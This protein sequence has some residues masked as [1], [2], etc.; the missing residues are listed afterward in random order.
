MSQRNLLH[1]AIV[2]ERVKLVSKL[3]NNG[4]DVDAKDDNIYSPLH[5][6]VKTRNVEIIKLL[7]DAGADPFAK[8]SGLIITPFSAAIESGNVAILHL[9]LMP[10]AV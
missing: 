5:L 1:A 6:A 7:F 2:N 9:F 4:C 10:S 8:E 3:I